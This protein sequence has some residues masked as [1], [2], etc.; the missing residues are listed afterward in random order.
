VRRTDGV[1]QL[2]ITYPKSP[3]TFD[4]SKGQEKPNGPSP[5]ESAQKNYT[6]MEFNKLN[7]FFYIDRLLNDN[8]CILQG[9][10]SLVTG[11]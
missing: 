4:E 11:A 6:H 3:H 1:N 10:S 9:Q 8:R 7:F 5:S 2:F